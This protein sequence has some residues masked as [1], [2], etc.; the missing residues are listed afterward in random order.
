M[1][2]EQRQ[3]TQNKHWQPPHPE[4]DDADLVF[5]FGDSGFFRSPARLA[6]IKKIYSKAHIFGCSTAG[7][8]QGAEVYDES[9][10]TTALRF[11][12]SRLAHAHVFLSQV[13]GAYEAGEKL[14]QALDPKDLVHV[15]VLSSSLSING[16]DLVRG[17]IKNLP[18]GVTLT[19]GIAGDQARFHE[20]FV[21][22]GDTLASDLVAIVGLYG[23]QLEIHSS[24]FGGW[25]PFGPERVITKSKGNILYELDGRPALDLYKVY[26]GDLAQELPDSGLLIPLL[27]RTKE[28]TQDMV[29]TVL[30]IDEKTKSMYFAGDVPEGASGRF[31]K[32]NPDRLIEGALGAAVNCLPRASSASPEL[33]LLVS[34]Y[35][36]RKILKQRVEEEVEGVRDVLGSQTVLA[37]FYSYGEISAR[38]PSAKSE[39][40]NQ[41]MTITT[42]REK[43]DEDAA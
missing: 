32:V 26:L 1:K 3:W 15:F 5:V 20:T 25:H 35:G 27:L 39:L 17:L 36:R 41:T 33:A 16:S 30:S 40:H 14:A 34:C 6:E 24:C 11:Q 31:M 42:L 18:E 21:I 13:S 7:E 29:R 8:I 43:G 4:L 38:H 2:V 12:H 37:G 9:L 23:T 28:R 19:G 10:S 22:S